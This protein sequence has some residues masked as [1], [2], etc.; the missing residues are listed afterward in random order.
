MNDKK[1]RANTLSVINEVS[2]MKSG[3]SIEL[4][5]FYIRVCGTYYSN[6]LIT[7]SIEPSYAVSRNLCNISIQNVLGDR[8]CFTFPNTKSGCYLENSSGSNGTKHKDGASTTTQPRHLKRPLTAGN[9][10]IYIIKKKTEQDYSWTFTKSL[11]QWN[12]KQ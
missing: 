12:H 8:T 9:S 3:K 10:L 7:K 11:K 4:M 5:F 2:I 6:T 1:R